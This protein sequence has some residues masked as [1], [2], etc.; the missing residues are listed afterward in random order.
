MTVAQ[1]QHKDVQAWEGIIIYS[2]FWRL[3][4]LC[5]EHTMGCGS[6]IFIP[7]TGKLQ[8]ERFKGII[9]THSVIILFTVML[10]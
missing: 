2:V 4:V 6:V 9:H 1:G 8:Y 7:C 10:L 3:D 5:K